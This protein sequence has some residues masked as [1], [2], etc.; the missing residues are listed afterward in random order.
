MFINN[1]IF[2]K[3]ATGL[4]PSNLIYEDDLAVAFKDTHPQAPVHAL[5]I[6]KDHYDSLKEI[7]DEALIGRLFTVAKKVAEKL[8]VTDYRIVINTGP[9]SGQTVYHLHIHLLGGRYMIWPPG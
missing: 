2:C 9:K 3:I 5:I 7:K 1:C 8:G 6:P 4:A